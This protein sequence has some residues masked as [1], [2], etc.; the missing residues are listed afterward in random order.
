MNGLD[1]GFST[2]ATRRR[3]ASAPLSPLA[4]EA[5]PGV[6][7]V[8]DFTRLDT[9]LRDA[10]GTT[11]VTATGQTV[12][13]VLD[14]RHAIGPELLANAEF[15]TDVASWSATGTGVT[16]TWEAGSARVIQDGSSNGGIWSSPSTTEPGMLLRLGCDLLEN[17]GNT[18]GIELVA[19]NNVPTGS[20]FRF[21]PASYQVIVPATD[22]QMRARVRNQ[23][24][25]ASNRLIGAMSLRAISGPY[26][27]Q[28]TAAKQP[29]YAITGLIDDGVDDALAPS[30]SG[31][32]SLAWAAAGQ[33]IYS[34][35]LS[36]D[37]QTDML[38]DG[39]TGLAITT[40]PISLVDRQRLALH[41]G[42]TA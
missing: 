21:L 17:S 19:T 10:I 23:N 9:L 33:L 36:V 25:A 3:Q 30:I 34:E 8:F 13:L 18:A 32:L 24:V 27:R 7:A 26:L 16:T 11:P 12:G 28:T 4:P 22:V 1:F 29:H 14:A 37:E 15:A 6:Q 42:V 2:L 38:R 40:Q 20:I 5:L 41:W 39:M 31:T 35:N